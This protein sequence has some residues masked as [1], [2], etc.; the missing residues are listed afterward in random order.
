MSS[1]DQNQVSVCGVEE[2]EEGGGGEEKYL[3]PT[4]G[5]IFANLDEYKAVIAAKLPTARNCTEK[6]IASPY[7]IGLELMGTNCKPD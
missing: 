2:Q 1:H 4:I 7:T 3:A 5:S 6:N